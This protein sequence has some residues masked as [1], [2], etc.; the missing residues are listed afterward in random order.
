[1][2]QWIV[3]FY[4]MCA[5]LSLPAQTHDERRPFREHGGDRL[6]AHSCDQAG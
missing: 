3:A 2:K 4:A 6:R 1:M 5:A